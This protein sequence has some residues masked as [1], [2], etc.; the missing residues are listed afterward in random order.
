MMATRFWAAGLGLRSVGQVPATVA[1]LSASRAASLLTT[2]ACRRSLEGVDEGAGIMR[3]PT[4]LAELLMRPGSWTTLYVDGPDG[5]PGPARTARRTSIRNRLERAGAPKA[6]VEA[7]LDA[8]PDEGPP[9]PSS[10]VVLVHDGTVE[11]DE[12]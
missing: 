3:A 11:L 5:A 12:F 1:M 10:H 2:T 9:A 7:A 8:L 6:D 4:E